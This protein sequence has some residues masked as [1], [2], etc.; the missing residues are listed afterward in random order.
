MREK[1][2]PGTKVLVCS[3][4]HGCSLDKVLSRRAKR[5]PEGVPFYA[6]IKR[7]DYYDKQNNVYTI[8]YSKES[9][10]G[11]YYIRS[12]FEVVDESFLKEEEF[13]V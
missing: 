3:K 2:K 12:D 10:G 6:W 4:S 11:D 13:L 9:P 1:L 5:Y 7:E 8:C